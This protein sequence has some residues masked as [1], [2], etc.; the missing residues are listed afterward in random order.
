MGTLLDDQIRR[1]RFKNALSHVRVHRLREIDGNKEYEYRIFVLTDA[2]EGRIYRLKM[3]NHRPLGLGAPQ[4]GRYVA[5][6]IT[7]RKGRLVLAF[8]EYPKEGGESVHLGM[9]EYDEH[10]YDKVPKHVVEYLAEGTVPVAD[11]EHNP[12][13][14]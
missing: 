3:S 10:E 8:G 7:A 11:D 6:T 1:E 13:K 9:L 4:E 2:C 14:E 12:Y 5:T